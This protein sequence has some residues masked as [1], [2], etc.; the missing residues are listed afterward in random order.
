[1]ACVCGCWFSLPISPD[2]A[3]IIP[4]TVFFFFLLLSERAYT[5]SSEIEALYYVSSSMSMS[6]AFDE[7]TLM[8][9]E[10]DYFDLHVSNVG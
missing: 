7:I 1:M 8:R 2:D 6:H 9:I 5:R 3:L 10:F 4:T